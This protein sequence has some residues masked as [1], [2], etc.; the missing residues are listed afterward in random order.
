M[1][2]SLLRLHIITHIIFTI[3]ANKKYQHF[4]VHVIKKISFNW[5]GKILA[6]SLTFVL[7]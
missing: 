7:T 1:A 6:L 3:S 2:I 5:P 4:N